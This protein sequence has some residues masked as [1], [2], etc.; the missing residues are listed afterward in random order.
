MNDAENRRLQMFVRVRD[1]GS[2]HTNDFAADSAGKEL[3]T[4]LSSIVDTLEGHA[5]AETSGRGAAMQGT[6]SRA[7]ARDALRDRLEAINRTARALEDEI[8]GLDDQFR[9]P[10]SNN[11]QQLLATAGAFVTDAPSVSAKFTAYEL[12]ADFIDELKADIAALETAISEQSSGVVD[13]VTARAAIDEAID[14][15]IL[16]VRKLDAIVR[17]KYAEQ[18][19]VIAAWTSVSHTER[20]PRHKAAT[21]SPTGPTVTAAPPAPEI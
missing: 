5:S 4:T 13:H 16:T 20:A 7:Q 18:P 8:P 19:E 21:A 1:F 11:D 6:A 9:I 15:G 12:P 2:A 3:F 14:Q 17:N 10:R